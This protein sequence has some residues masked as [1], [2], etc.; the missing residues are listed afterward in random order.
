MSSKSDFLFFNFLSRLLAF[1]VSENFKR[2]KDFFK[3]IKSAP[4]KSLFFSKIS[5]TPI[6]YLYRI[7]DFAQ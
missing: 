6:F 3:V 7:L 1:S 4:L 5:N 2:N